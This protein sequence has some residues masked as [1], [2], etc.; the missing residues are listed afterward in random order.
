M[1]LPPLKLR[2]GIREILP[3]LP[4]CSIILTNLRRATIM[5]TCFPYFPLLFSYIP[6]PTTTLKIILLVSFWFQNT[7]FALRNAT[8]ASEQ[9]T[10]PSNFFSL[11]QDQPHL[12]ICISFSIMF[13]HVYLLSAMQALSSTTYT[14]SG[15]SHCS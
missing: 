14:A 1:L 9:T 5:S 2:Q 8:P 10:I 7:L 12:P 4:W 6:C 13:I 15:K 3:T 11:H